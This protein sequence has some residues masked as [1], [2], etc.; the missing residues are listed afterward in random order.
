MQ[1]LYKALF[2]IPPQSAAAE[3]YPE[4]HQSAYRIYPKIDH[5]Y[6]DCK[7]DD[8]TTAK[9]LLDRVLIVVVEFYHHLSL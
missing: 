8:A 4:K 3:K 5:E 9:Q 1:L 6:L 7:V 2:I